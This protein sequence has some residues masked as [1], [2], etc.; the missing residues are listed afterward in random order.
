MVATALTFKLVVIVELSDFCVVRADL[1]LI[2]SVFL[3]NTIFGRI[4]G[5]GEGRFRLLAPGRGHL[6]GDFGGARNFHMRVLVRIL[7]LVVAVEILMGKLSIMEVVG[8]IVSNL[9]FLES[10]E[11]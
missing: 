4:G 9:D 8:F 2:V 1:N 11:Y 3:G 7:K 6:G 5:A 10:I